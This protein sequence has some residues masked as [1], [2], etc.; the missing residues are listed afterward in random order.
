M[1]QYSSLCACF[2]PVEPDVDTVERKWKTFDLAFD[3]NCP[4]RALSVFFLWWAYILQK[5]WIM[6]RCNFEYFTLWIFY[7]VMLQKFCLYVRLFNTLVSI[8][9]SIVLFCQI[10]WQNW[11]GVGFIESAE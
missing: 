10:S 7:R 4:L 3:W 6:W 11:G 2:T 5:S 1:R 8:Q 9:L